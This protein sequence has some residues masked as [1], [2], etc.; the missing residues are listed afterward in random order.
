M[1]KNFVRMKN[2]TAFL[3]SLCLL[4]LGS[5]RLSLTPANAKP[6]RPGIIRVIQKDGSELKIRAYGDEFYHYFTTEDGYALTDA[7]DGNWY[8]AKADSKGNLISTGIK[9]KPTRLLSDAERSQIHKN[10]KPTGMTDEQLRMKKICSTPSTVQTKGSGELS[11]PPVAAGTTWTAEG[12]KKILVLLAEYKDVPFTAGTKSAFSSLLNDTDYSTNGATGSV[13][14]YYYDNS[15]GKFNPEFVVAGPYTLSK[16]RSSYTNDAAGM[17]TEVVKLADADIDFSEY[18]ENGTVR[19]VFV[20][21]SGGAKSDA[22]ADAIWPHRSQFVSAITLDGV[23][24]RGYACSSELEATSN[25]TSVGFATI[26]SFCHE[27]GHIIGWPDL[28]DNNSDNGNADGPRF[29]S[30]MDV[31]CYNNGGKTP[32]TLGILERWMLG[33]AEPVELTSEGTATLEPVSDNHGYIIRTD[34]AS[35][36]FT[37]E[38]RGTDKSVWDKKDYLD[39][40]NA[41]ASWGLTVG[42]VDIS[43]T[44]GWKNYAP[45]DIPGKEGFTLIRSDSSSEKGI[46]AAYIPSHCFFPGRNSVT[47]LYSNASTGFISRDGGLTKMEI[48]DIKL[49][50]S[51][52]TVTLTLDEPS[53]E[54]SDVTSEVFEHDALLSWSDDL[55]SSWTVTWKEDGANANSGSAT[56]RSKEIHIPSLKYGQKYTVSIS[57]DRSEKALSASLTT[58]SKSEGLPRIALSESTPKSGEKILT[59]LT[60]CENFVDVQW[61]M[62]GAKSDG[63]TSFTKGEHY[64]QAI[65]TYPDGSKQYFSRYINIIL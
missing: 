54:I 3:V 22:V 35:E 21:F 34:N 41:G 40:Y 12:K 52:K 25:G 4:L 48:T 57:G 65:A 56:V 50:E 11:A 24:L 14:K 39:Y 33:W 26:G 5:G 59:I 15:D 47:S 23:S 46:S 16:P 17:V 60:G 38:C 49:N 44:A 8:Y 45:N 6:A 10:L 7:G 62:D 9:A 51:E 2:S 36:Y 19:D 30:L 55:S 64:I 37:L 18:A 63:Y 20:F 29:F 13:W 61:Y 32:P 53:T 28:Y 43:N 27:F 42:H 31:G 1:F 58:A